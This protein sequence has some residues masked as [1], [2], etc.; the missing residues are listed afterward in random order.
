MGISKLNQ[1]NRV[2][3]AMAPT[4]SKKSRLA[5]LNDELRAEL[6]HLIKEKSIE[7]DETIFMNEKRNPVCHENFVSRRFL[8][9]TK[10]WGGRVIRFHDLRHS[11]TTMMIAGGIDIKTVKE[12]CGHA[13]IATTMTYVHLISGAVERVAQVFSV[14]RNILQPQ[15]LL[16]SASLEDD[17]VEGGESI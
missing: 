11:A 14:T 2:I 3:L 13:D 9:D 16:A 10:A 1:F 4:K 7:P 6:E 15:L 8:V 17:E 5:P 12:I